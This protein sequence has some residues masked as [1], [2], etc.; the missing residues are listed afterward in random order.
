MGDADRTPTLVP[1]PECGFGNDAETAFCP[2]CGRDL[3]PKGFWQRLLRRPEQ[4]ASRSLQLQQQHIEQE[5]LAIA[6]DIARFERQA[7]ELRDQ[8][9]AARA[10][11]RDATPLE[12]AIGALGDAL[13][14]RRALLPRYQ[15]I[16]REI[17]LDRAENQLRLLL[18][19]IDSGDDAERLRRAVE[20]EPARAASA[21]EAH[22]GRCV[23]LCAVGE[24]LLASAGEDGYVR[25]WTV[26]ELEAQAEL[27]TPSA[28]RALACSD[29]GRWLAAGGLDGQLRVWELSAGR[30]TESGPQQLRGH[31]DWISSLSFRPGG[32]EL[33]SAS[34]D[35]E[36]RLWSLQATASAEGITL[37][38]GGGLVRSVVFTADGAQ[39]ALARLSGPAE[40][41]DI[42]ARRVEKRAELSAG[43]GAL[44]SSPDGALLTSIAGR[45]LELFSLREG[46]VVSQLAGS[47][48]LAD[49]AFDPR[50]RILAWGDAAGVLAI[51][52]RDGQAEASWASEPSQ[53]LAAH[54]CPLRAVAFDTSGRFLA[55]A[56]EDG[57]M[58]LW[59]L[60]RPSISRLARD[61]IAEVAQLM[62]DGEL[63]R[64]EEG[65]RVGEHAWR[66]LG[67]LGA[68]LAH[69]QARRLLALPL[70]ALDDD[71]VV[72]LRARVRLLLEEIPELVAGLYPRG[73]DRLPGALLKHLEQL[74]RRTLST[75]AD[76]L[77]STTSAQ[78]DGLHS[79][80]EGECDRRAA[81]LRG[82]VAL[83]AELPAKLEQAGLVEA[84]STCEATARRLPELLD[85]V[86]ARRATAA[87][88]V[89]SPF[90][91]DAPLAELAAEREALLAGEVARAELAAA[92]AEVEALLASGP[93]DEL[94]QRD[95]ALAAIER[96]ASRLSDE[97]QA[98][99][100]VDRLLSS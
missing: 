59:D 6:D 75:L 31:G 55:S 7:A 90:D 29:D 83:A 45:R 39:L 98:I 16:S 78:L 24:G 97:Q 32:H 65:R 82:C 44:R 10:A 69:V 22:L 84:A 52:A 88:G 37:T 34:G 18:T 87:V 76:T 54:G 70:R 2:D 5:R 89:V 51:V 53:T 15:A 50:G 48:T 38:R 46:Y 61:A 23:A 26:P 66:Y 56:A 71:A 64:S 20:G 73:H 58:T 1:C 3:R 85:L 41:W 12:Q 62:E 25:L 91:D 80:S 60:E 67:E 8:R 95:R 9:Q 86:L 93:R 49:H 100:E 68:A 21:P 11:G 27:A 63:L 17:A 42:G 4:R 96:E 74:P 79:A 77:L 36:V 94:D 35:G 14:E 33:A 81:T 57:G 47:E 92:E 99:H 19:R 30:P 28:L 72:S 43:F 13:D 40:L